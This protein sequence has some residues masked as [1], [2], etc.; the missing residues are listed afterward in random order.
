MTDA[1]YISQEWIWLDSYDPR[2]GSA[3]H[4]NGHVAK[5]DVTPEQ[6][7]ALLDGKEVDLYGDGVLY[8]DASLCE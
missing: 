6:W 7:K 2:T 3:S 5:C 4:N 1:E 8:S